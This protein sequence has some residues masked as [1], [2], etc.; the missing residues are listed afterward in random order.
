VNVYDSL[1][2]AEREALLAVLESLD[3]DAADANDEA[4]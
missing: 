2:F 3:V 4:T 1:S